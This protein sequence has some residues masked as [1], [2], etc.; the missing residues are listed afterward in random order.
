MPSEAPED[1]DALRE[2]IIGLGETSLHKSYYP[3]LQSRLAELERFRALLDQTYDAIFLLRA[4]TGMLADVS[5]SVSAYLG[6]SKKELLRKPFI[7]LISPQQKA[8]FAEFIRESSDMASESGQT[9]IAPLVARDGTEIPMEITVRSVTFGGERYVV[10]IARDITERI[11]TERELRIKESALES[12]TNGILIADPT[13]AVMYANRSF[14]AMFGYDGAGTIA[15]KN[16]G[17]FFADP[18]VGEKVTAHLLDDHAIVQETIGLRDDGSQ[19]HIQI[20]GSVVQNGAGQPLCI[21]LIV[22]DITERVL[23]EQ[24]R[25]ETYAQLGKNIE[26]FAILGDH[27]RNPLQ[28]IVGY[29]EM[30]DDPFAEKILEESRRIDGFVTELDR[31]WLRSANVRQFLLRH[32]DGS[33]S[34]RRVFFR[35]SNL[36]EEDP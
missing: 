8:R 31:G 17:A 28:V 29:A 5:A 15:G 32:G 11:R 6:Y 27:I 33:S 2:K 22:M 10:A 24:M 34:A 7:D 3:E 12:S 16:L 13:G 35:F 26:Q 30:I 23:A 36:N 25:R 18:T 20:S 4:E 14:V 21:M 9:F 1:R 19:F